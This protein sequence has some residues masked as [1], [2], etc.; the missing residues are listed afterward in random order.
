[1]RTIARLTEQVNALAPLL[2]L[3]SLP[4]RHERVVSELEEIK[5]TT[6]M[7]INALREQL[8]AQQAEMD[9]RNARDAGEIDA[10]REQMRAEIDAPFHG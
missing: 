9:A 4:E 5:G 1:M 6:R 2:A 8:E 7:E 3:V 10:Q